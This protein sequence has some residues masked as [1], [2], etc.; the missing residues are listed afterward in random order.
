MHRA[1][2]DFAAAVLSG[3]GR[4]GGS[5]PLRGTAELLD[6]YS[7]MP[8]LRAVVHKVSHSV[9][10][11]PW[12]VFVARNT[13][14]KFLRV[15]KLQRGDFATR[16]RI[17][18]SM[19]K[20][21]EFIELEDHPILDLLNSGSKWFPGVTSSQLTQAYLDLVGEAVQLKE[22]ST[23]ISS[24]GTRRGVVKDLW[25]IP[26]NWVR[27]LPTLDNPFFEIQFGRS[28]Q[29]ELVPMDDVVYFRDPN[30][31]DPF[32]R[33]SGTAAALG[34]ELQAN[35]AAS[36]TIRSRLENNSIPPFLAMPDGES[37]SAPD[38]KQL[39]R[40]REDWQKRLRGPT[41]SGFVHFLRMKFKI[42]K[43]GNTFEELSL[44]PLLHNQRD[45]II[46]VYGVPPEILGVLANSNRATIESAELLM[47]KHVMVPRVELRRAV[48]QETIVPEFDERLI[49]D[50][51]SPVP[52]DKQYELEVLKSQPWAFT[53]DEIR[54]KGGREALP[55]GQGQV[56]A[57]PMNVFLTSTLTGHDHDHGDEDEPEEPE[58]P[59]DEPEEPQEP[60][61]DPEPD[62]TQGRRSI[63]KQEDR[64]ARRISNA[65]NPDQL[66]DAT[67]GPMLDGIGSAGQARLDEIG[68]GISFDIQ[69]PKVIEFMASQ[70]ANQV[71]G[72]NRTTRRILRK[73]LTEGLEEGESIGQLTRRVKDTFAQASGRR[74]LV[75]ART[76]SV[77]ALNV[78]QV[79]ATK[80]AGFE[81]KQWLST[82]DPKVRE[83]HAVGTGM[84]GQIVPVDGM[85]VSPSGAAGPH[86]G[87]MSTAAESVNCRCTILSVAK[88]PGVADEEESLLVWP[89]NLDSEEKR[90]Q[91]WKAAE[92]IRL[93]IE[94][95]LREAFRRGFSV[96]Q[97]AVLKELRNVLEPERTSVRN[98]RKDNANAHA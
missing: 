72:I 2:E 84:D 82:R 54:E 73:T 58:E 30:P 13:D 61:D 45:T 80:Q 35:E 47:A 12:R 43:L 88:V 87:A 3:G 60:E 11:V 28:G 37:T 83:T 16:R 90:V 31:R 20:E 62:P 74:A 67:N 46:Q 14:G 97:R 5:S 27:S 93:P 44:I 51:E 7:R 89:D 96:Q 53:A 34:D 42:E 8:W 56:Y 69:D 76:E 98:L 59:E 66:N 24:P 63:T 92:R 86:P 49:L 52:E 33:G 1:G 39:E 41:K 68:I 17:M 65:A 4:F 36:V 32:G 19:R 25:P 71:V 95:S 26:P 21:V 10:M 70:G 55:D 75:I 9:A 22:R 64:R 91:Y 85:F 23:R 29:S 38:P 57:V 94:R 15:S 79:A 78:G 81:G 77:R 6:A 18:H 50:Y 48:Y 40:I